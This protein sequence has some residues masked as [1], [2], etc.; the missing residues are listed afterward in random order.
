METAVTFSLYPR[1]FRLYSLQKNMPRQK[2]KIPFHLASSTGVIVNS[3]MLV[4]ISNNQTLA[5]YSL[6]II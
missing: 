4:S 2:H 1:T 6:M 3:K 5:S